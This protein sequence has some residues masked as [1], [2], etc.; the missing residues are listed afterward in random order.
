[1]NN[2]DQSQYQER[3]EFQRHP[4]DLRVQLIRSDTVPMQLHTVE[5]SMGGMH[6]ECDRAQAQLLA[7]PDIGDGQQFT[8]RVLLSAPGIDG[9]ALTLSAVV[10]SVVELGNDR[11]RIGLHFEKFFGKSYRLLEDFVRALEN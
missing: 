5:L 3:R 8:A 2:P 4:S 9:R 6:V 10:K 1:M 7:P 11:Y